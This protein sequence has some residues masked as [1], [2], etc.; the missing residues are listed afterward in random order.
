MSAT[1]L[2]HSVRRA[3]MG[4]IDDLARLLD[5]QAAHNTTAAEI[6][7]LLND[8]QFLVLDRP[9][10]GIAASIYL[11]IEGGCGRFDHLAVDD[12]VARDH[13]DSQLPQ[14]LVSVAEL[15]CRAE[16]CS[17]VELEPGADEDL[18][19]GDLSASPRDSPRST[20]GRT[21]R[22]RRGAGRRRGGRREADGVAVLGSRDPRTDEGSWRRGS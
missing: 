6:R 13:L 19:R 9:G 17:R 1:S 14:R 16:G 8:G 18:L 20:R 5:Q 15:V 2:S 3:A 10:G 11:T 4:D 22:S 12:D 7:G 21:R